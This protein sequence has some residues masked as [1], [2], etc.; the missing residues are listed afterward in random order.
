MDFLSIN[1]Y[2]TEMSQTIRHPVILVRADWDDEASVWVASSNDIAG[3]AAESPTLEAL[4]VKVLAM[5]GELVEL[6]GFHSDLP[7]IP[8]HIIAGHTSKIPNPIFA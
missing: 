8:V 6:N 3:L 7:E 4:Q 5:I 1:S 2:I